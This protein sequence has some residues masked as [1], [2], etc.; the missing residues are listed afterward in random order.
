MRCDQSP[1]ERRAYWLLLQLSIYGLG[2]P[3]AYL[4][5]VLHLD[6]GDRVDQ[7]WVLVAAAELQYTRN[8]TECA[9][10]PIV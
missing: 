1:L 5:M 3:E 4:N 10:R 6:R 7:R 9:A 8:E 2:D